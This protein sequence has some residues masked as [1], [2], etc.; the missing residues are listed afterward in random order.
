ML[1]FLV[2]KLVL[3][4]NKPKYWQKE[5]E[6]LFIS[7]HGEEKEKK[8][9]Q[10]VLDEVDELHYPSLDDQSIRTLIAHD[11]NSESGTQIGLLGVEAEDPTQE[12]QGTLATGETRDF[13]GR[14]K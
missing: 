2:K 3:P 13:R 10:D 12:K 14:A 5:T 11:V 8:E 6:N 1:E 4:H 9:V 7:E